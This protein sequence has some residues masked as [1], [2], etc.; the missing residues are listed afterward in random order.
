MIFYI[1]KYALAS[2]TQKLRISRT[3]LIRNLLQFRHSRVNIHNIL[4]NLSI[5]FCE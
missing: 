4:I 1:T 2:I 3:R 5:S